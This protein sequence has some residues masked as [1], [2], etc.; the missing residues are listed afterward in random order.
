MSRW[1]AE[2]L[3]IVDET[4]GRVAVECHVMPLFGPEHEASKLCW[5]HPETDKHGLTE[6]NVMH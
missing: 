1:M 5:C 4:T 2:V 3:E 6:H